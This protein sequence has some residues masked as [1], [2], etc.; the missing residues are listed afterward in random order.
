MMMEKEILPI[1]IQFVLKEFDND[2]VFIT[3]LF[4]AFFESVEKKIPYMERAAIDKDDKVLEPEAHAIKGGAANI[5]ANLLSKAAFDLMETCK[6]NRVDQYRE[7]L[8]K[9]KKEFFKLKNYVEKH[10]D[11]MP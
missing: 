1:D 10:D 6:V 9:I 4:D 7:N 3:E 2:V 8:E 5:G 11:L